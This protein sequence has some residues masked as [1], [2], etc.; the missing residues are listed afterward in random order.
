[1]RKN[2]SFHT[3]SLDSGGRRLRKTGELRNNVAELQNGQIRTRFAT[4]F[5]FC[6]WFVRSFVRS[7]HLVPDVCYAETSSGPELH[8]WYWYWDESYSWDLCT[9]PSSPRS[10]VQHR[11]CMSDID[12]QPEPRV[13]TNLQ[14][15]LIP[16]A[17]LV[18]G[19]LLLSAAGRTCLR[20]DHVPQVR[21]LP[22]RFR[23]GKYP[24]EPLQSPNTA[25]SVRTRA[26]RR[27]G[28]SPQIQEIVRRAVVPP[29][30][31][32]A[33]GDRGVSQAPRRVPPATRARCPTRRVVACAG[34]L[35]TVVDAT[36]SSTYSVTPGYLSPV[37]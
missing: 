37:V 20:Y 32:L 31:M 10:P 19:M 11:L 23:T 29:R 22:A 12:H 13:A 30:D 35:K 24:Y 14:R 21:S 2:I 4:L 27:G 34:P 18:G 7:P 36:V 17:V 3:R 15:T 16:V 28:H 6:S 8:P 25:Y 1:M 26:L 5:N 33:I 9:W